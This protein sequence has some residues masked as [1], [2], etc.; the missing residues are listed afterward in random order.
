M[1]RSCCHLSLLGLLLATSAHADSLV[2]TD[3][4]I[5][6]S[7]GGGGGAAGSVIVHNGVGNIGIVD[8]SRGNVSLAQ[9]GA[10]N[11]ALIAT[12]GTK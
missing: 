9:L 4:A 12:I 1:R 5:A 7:G 11:Y 3:Q 10:S 6:T 8:Q 2:A